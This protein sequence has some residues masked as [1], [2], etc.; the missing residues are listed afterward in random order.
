MSNLPWF[1]AYA[2]IVDNEKIRLV[3]FE[4]RWHYV[5][6]LACKAQGILDSK[7][8]E[9]KLSVKLGLQLRELDE[10]KRR[11]CEVDL[12]DEN[13]QP[14]GWN[15]K[16]FRSDTDSTANERK[17]RQRAK[18]I[19]EKS[20]NINNLNDVTDMSRVTPSVTVTNV[21]RTETETDT[22]N[23]NKLL[24]S[25]DMSRHI[26]QASIENLP[27]VHDTKKTVSRKKIPGG[28]RIP[29]QV[30]DVI[31][32]MFELGTLD[33]SQA[34]KFFDY[35]ASIGWTVGKARAPMQDWKAAAR[36]WLKNSFGTQQTFQ[37]FSESAQTQQSADPFSR[38]DWLTPHLDESGSFKT[39]EQRVS[40]RMQK[41]GFVADYRR[42]QGGLV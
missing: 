37:T 30:D 13:W 27:A 14:I 39:L 22:D 18:Q 2:N 9:R 32:Y 12:I 20:I 31:Q 36:N 25:C 15:E 33:A 1:R 40:E 41:E 4:D 16:Q 28:G 42:D 8:V 17:R 35:Y 24:L 6:I 29:A 5:A 23:N 11:L 7:L 38:E 34:I 19:E 3:A 26:T 10:V 21:T